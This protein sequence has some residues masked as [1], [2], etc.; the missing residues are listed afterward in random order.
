LSKS[1]IYKIINEVK[2]EGNTDT[3]L[4]L[5][6]KNTKQTMDFVA[7]MATDVKADCLVTCTK[8]ATAHGVSFGTIHNILHVELGLVKKSVCWVPKLLSMELKE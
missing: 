8:I 7:A 1:E 6:P 5:N 4:H 2:A 3:Q